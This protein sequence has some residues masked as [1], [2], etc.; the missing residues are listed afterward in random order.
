MI[1]G[2]KVIKY[3]RH[4]QKLSGR[5]SKWKTGIEEEKAFN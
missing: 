4:Y 1:F 5:T 2:D 3:K